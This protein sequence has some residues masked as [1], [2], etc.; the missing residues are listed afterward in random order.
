MKK[1]LSVSAL[2]AA[3]AISAVAM[4]YGGSPGGTSAATVD[5]ART[6]TTTAPAR[7]HAPTAKRQA[8]TIRFTAIQGARTIRCGT[9][10]TGVGTTKATTRLQDLRLYVS[11]VRLVRRNGS[12]VKLQLRRNDAW[13]LTRGG[14]AVTLIDLENGTSGCAGDARMNTVITGTVP[15]GTYTGITYTLGM[16]LALNHTD[17]TSSPAPLNLIAMTWSWQSGRKFTQIELDAPSARGVTGPDFFVHLGSTGCKGVPTGTNAMTCTAPNRAKVLLRS[18]NPATQRI[19]LDI[20]AL[21]STVDVTR[22]GG[23]AS[24]CMSGPTDPECGGVFRAMGL[25]WAANGSGTGR[26]VGD[27]ASQRL[28]RVVK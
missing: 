23:G 18:F 9:R 8:V 26:T 3:L 22:N 2:G 24:G 21:T 7:S 10:L 17:P 15:K 13:N 27:G 5:S 4:A 1:L 19:A 20:G 28:F 16:P 6:A 14:Q 12:S 11:N 25:N